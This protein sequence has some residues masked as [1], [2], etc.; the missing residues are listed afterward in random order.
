[1]Q[2]LSNPV[3]DSNG[4]IHNNASIHIDGVCS[5]IDL[6]QSLTVA[7]VVLSSDDNSDTEEQDTSIPLAAAQEVYPITTDD[8][9]TSD[10]CGTDVVSSEFDHLDSSTGTNS[11]SNNNTQDTTPVISYDDHNEQ[12]QQ[13]EPHYQTPSSILSDGNSITA[14]GKLLKYL[15][16]EP[17]GGIDK[18]AVQEAPAAWYMSPSPSPYCHDMSSN[19]NPT[20]SGEFTTSDLFSPPSHPI[21]SPPAFISPIYGDQHDEPATNDNDT[22]PPPPPPSLPLQSPITVTTDP[23]S[24]YSIPSPSYNRDSSPNSP[25]YQSP[26]A[27]THSVDNSHYDFVRSPVTKQPPN[28]PSPY[29]R[30]ASSPLIRLK[31]KDFAIEYTLQSQMKPVVVHSRDCRSTSSDTDGHHTSDGVEHIYSHPRPVFGSYSGRNTPETPR[32]GY[33]VHTSIYQY[34]LQSQYPLL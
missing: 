32:N 16:L 14:S 21:A 19:M 27:L 25:H 34:T 18:A 13:H 22:N 28:S 26:L 29:R 12:Q 17:D 8:G 15:K 20:D 11:N 10:L 2:A 30:G 1:M 4:L 33:K 24:L 6:Q 9:T 23:H 3:Q 5:S 7:A 31:E